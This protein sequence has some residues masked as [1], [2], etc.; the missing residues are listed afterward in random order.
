MLCI[1]GG[2]G[3]APII[4]ILQEELASGGSR[5]VILLYG[6]RSQRHLYCLDEIAR[7]KDAWPAQFSFVPTLSEE[8]Q[9]SDWTGARGLVTSQLTE[10]PDLPQHEAYLC[11]PPAMVDAAEKLL[12]EAGLERD[13][14]SADRF[15]DRSTR[16]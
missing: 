4:A 16:P 2:S 12:L 10:I 3:L 9:D 15:V 11:G 7:L 8:P 14:I 6:A 5:P 13:A 1:A